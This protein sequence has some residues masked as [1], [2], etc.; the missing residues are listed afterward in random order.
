MLSYRHGFHAGNFADVC[1]HAILALLVQA[2][3]RKDKPFL[4]LDT[5]AGAGRY[6]LGSMMAKK[7]REYAGGISRLWGRADLPAAL[8]PYLDAVAAQN[9]G[10]ALQVYPGSPQ[11]VRHFLRAQDRMALCELHSR[12]VEHLKDTFA[13]DRQVVVQSVDGYQGL[14]AFLPPPER[15]ALVLIDPAFELK[16]ERAQLLEALAMAH[17]RFPNG[18]YAIWYPIQDRPTL[19]WFRRQLERSGIRNILAAELRIF[20]EDLPLRLNGTGMVIINPPWQLDTELNALGPWLWQ[21][22]SAE[23]QGGFKLD[24]LAPE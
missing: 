15:R 10:E 21:A 2:Q 20:D 12:E 16:G 19:D 24:W 18:V 23:G 5:H 22:L 17:K 1:K 14:R 9:S 7:N 13:G 4:Y 11:I 8:R 6:D 3:L